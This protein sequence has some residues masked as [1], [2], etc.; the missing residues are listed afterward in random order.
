MPA[1]QIPWHLARM[2][3]PAR[4]CRHGYDDDIFN[5][6]KCAAQ[7]SPCAT[8]PSPTRRSRGAWQVIR[9]RPRL[10]KR[11]VPTRACH[12]CPLAHWALA[13]QRLWAQ[14]C[15]AVLDARMLGR[16]SGYPP[17]HSP[18]LAMLTHH[19]AAFADCPRSTW[20]PAAHCTR[21]HHAR[22][23]LL[24]L[25]HPPPASSLPVSTSLAGI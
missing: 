7:T 6:S 13:G 23:H 11:Y 8:T 1:L 2:S 5:V 15:R 14:P 24:R 16:R 18:T 21:R 10:S 22:R 9:A 3:A 25:R 17:T 20:L 19:R 4:L 12:A